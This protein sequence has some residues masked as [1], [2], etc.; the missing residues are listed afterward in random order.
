MVNAFQ[1][2]RIIQCRVAN[3]SVFSGFRPDFP[4][5]SGSESH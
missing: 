3:P 2:I 1:N 5:S 4:G